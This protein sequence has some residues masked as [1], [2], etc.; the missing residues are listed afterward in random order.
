MRVLKRIFLWLLLVAVL[1]VLLVGGVV[2]WSYYKTDAAAFELPAVNVGGTSLAVNG[3]TWNVPVMG[4]LL[5]KSSE[6]P[7][8][9]Q[10][11]ELGVWDQASLQHLLPRGRSSRKPEKLCE[12]LL[13]GTLSIP[14][15]PKKISP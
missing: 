4:G 6:A 12:M 7:A 11:Q 14:P 9:L 3:Y 5:Y 2:A 10:A 13:K 15:M 8:T 1:V